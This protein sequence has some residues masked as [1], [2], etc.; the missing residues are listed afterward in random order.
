MC[1]TGGR[2]AGVYGRG[3]GG[4]S[5]PS[6][7]RVFNFSSRSLKIVFTG[8]GGV[9]YLF[10]ISNNRAIRRE[11]GVMGGRR[12]TFELSRYRPAAC[13]IYSVIALNAKQ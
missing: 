2:G 11:V 8:G 13:Y 12:Q 4:A 3:R 1:N 5:N 10:E 7:N 6:T 9:I